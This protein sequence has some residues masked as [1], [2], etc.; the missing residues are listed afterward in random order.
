MGERL[1]SGGCQCGAVRFEVETDLDVTRTCNCSR[2]QRL[3]AVWA[4]API[5]KLRILTGQDNLTT[6]TFNRHVGR[7]MFCRTCGIE[8]FAMGTIAVVNANCLDDVDPRA[9][10]PDHADGRSV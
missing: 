1:Y 2:R 10:H 3:G 8:S 4:Y 6:Y 7:H 9:L 5:E